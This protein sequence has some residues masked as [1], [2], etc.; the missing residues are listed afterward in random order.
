[1]DND[2]GNI[3]IVGP[4]GAGKSTLARSLAASL[5][6]QAIEVDALAWD[7]NWELASDD[8]LRSRVERAIADDGWI[9][10][11]NY[12]R[13]LRNAAWPRAGTVVWLDFPLRVILPRIARRAWK[14]WRTKELLWGKNRETFWEHFLPNDRSLIWFSVRTHRRRQRDLEQA[15]VSGDFPWLRWVR[16]R[17][18]GEVSRWL[19]VVNARADGQGATR[20][21]ATRP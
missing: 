11:G 13:I 1:M 2:H 20:F 4:S 14:R 10:D 8:E 15:M 18:P 5:G 9:A 12:T 21:R 16:L 6:L 3:L 19:G 7:A 17:S